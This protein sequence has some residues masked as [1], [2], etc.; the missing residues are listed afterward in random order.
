M[1]CVQFGIGFICFTIATRYIM[2]SEV[3]LFALSESILSPIW[4][5]IGVGEK[6][7]LLTLIGSAI[8]FVSVTAY[9]I[10]GIR[11]ERK[12]LQTVTATV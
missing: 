6:P 5:W 7:S 9:C 11:E 1:G 10:V 8:V 12:R 3:A 4:V 2:A